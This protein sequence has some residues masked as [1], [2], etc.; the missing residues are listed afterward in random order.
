MDMT[1]RVVYSEVQQVFDGMNTFP[2]NL[3]D[4]TNGM[5]MI[6]I[7]NGDDHRMKRFIIQK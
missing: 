4:L 2:I 6:N 7:A 1:G 5:Y 3:P